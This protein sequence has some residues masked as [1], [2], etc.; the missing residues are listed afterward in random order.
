MLSRKSRRVG[1]PQKRGC[2]VPHGP[3]ENLE[4][5]QSPGKGSGKGPG[6][7]APDLR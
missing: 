7:T 4:P 2:N 5:T 1:R 6:M 3:A